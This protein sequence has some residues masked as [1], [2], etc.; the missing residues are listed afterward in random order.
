ALIAVAVIRAFYIGLESNA[1]VAST[2]AFATLTLARLFHG[3]NCRSEKSIIS[4]GLF[5]N[6]ASIGAFILGLLLLTVAL[7]VPGLHSL[8]SVTDLTGQQIGTII[9]LALTPT[10]VIQAAKLL[11]GVKKK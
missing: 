7:F 4:I 9:G 3:F 2:M 5:S 6:P 8:F 10:L 1:A 11:L